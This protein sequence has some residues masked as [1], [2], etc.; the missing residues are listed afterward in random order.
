MNIIQKELRKKINKEKAAFFPRFFKSGNGQYGEGDKFLGV[1][2]PEQRAIAKKFYQDVEKETIIELL[3]SP[4]HEDRLTGLFILNLK[5]I[6]AKKLATEKE[7]FDL[8][9][10][11][12][13]R[14]NNWDLVD[15]SAY[16][17]IGQWLENKDRS[18]LYSFARDKN[19]W[20]NRIAMLS[21]FHFIKQGEMEDALQ[22]AEILLPHSH[23][24]IHKAVGWMLREA[25]KRKPALIEAFIKKHIAIFPRT[26]LRYAIE[27]MDEQ[28]RKQFLHA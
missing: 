26:A 23:D 2:V 8:Y 16:I 4:Y 25:W 3:D 14:V 24:L 10:K 12:I 1:I 6:A 21:T 11:K 18:I 27:K 15:S 13:N 20:L 17:I 5:F 7:W 22:I 19:L 9:L 28:K